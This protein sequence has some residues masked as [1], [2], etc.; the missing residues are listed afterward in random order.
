MIVALM[1]VSIALH[2]QCD[3]SL[4]ERDKF[5][6]QEVKETRETL[7]YGGLTK[8]LFFKIGSQEGSYYIKLKLMLNNVWSINQD[9]DIIMLLADR[10]KIILNPQEYVLSESNN[11]SISSSFEGV[12]VCRLSNDQ[13]NS[14]RGVKIESIRFNMNRDQ[15]DFDIKKRKQ[16]VLMD[17][18]VCAS[19]GFGLFIFFLVFF[20]WLSRELYKSDYYNSK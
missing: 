12:V 11:S 19:S 3:Y 9:K 13:M 16:S 7:L 15:I 1:V 18:S 2:A 14:I 17:R 4:K 20:G 10:S 6:G 5:T 8:S